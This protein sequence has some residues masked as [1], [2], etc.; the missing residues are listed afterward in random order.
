MS[1]LSKRQNTT[2]GLT[3][4]DLSKKPAVV[5]RMGEQLIR[6]SNFHQLRTIRLKQEKQKA[7]EEA[8][9]KHALQKMVSELYEAADE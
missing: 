7:R 2:S 1:S 4:S 9:K 3:G 6:Q 5:R 8:K